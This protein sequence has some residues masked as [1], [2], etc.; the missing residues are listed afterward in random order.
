[1][2]ALF[3]RLLVVGEQL[4]I[5]LKDLFEHELGPL[6]ASLLDDFGCLRKGDESVIVKKLG[7]V[8]EAEEKA[9]IIRDCRRKPTA[10]PCNLAVSRQ[11]L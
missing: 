5:D 4:G 11:S 8:S 1:M 6:P 7:D 9:D 2:E 10:L 3:A